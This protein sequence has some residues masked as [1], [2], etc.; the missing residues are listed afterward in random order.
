MD[1]VGMQRLCG[2]ESDA[3]RH[4]VLTRPLHR[5]KTNAV[6]MVLV[7]TAYL[8]VCI[9]VCVAFLTLFPLPRAARVALAVATTVG[10]A[11]LSAKFVCIKA[12]ECYQHYAKEE[13]RRRCLCMPTCSEYALAVLKKYPLSVALRKIRKRLFVTCSG[14]IY[15]KDPP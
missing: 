2:V 3:V 12:V 14:A 13:T 10:V 11:L 1:M 8:T 4:Y 7:L 9:G 5:P 6:T 15:L